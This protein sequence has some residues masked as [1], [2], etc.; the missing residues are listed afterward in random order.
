MICSPVL[1]LSSSFT[2]ALLFHISLFLRCTHWPLTHCP[3]HLNVMT[4]LFNL[5]YRS[6][7]LL[8]TPFTGCTI[9]YYLNGTIIYWDIS[10]IFWIKDYFQCLM[11]INRYYNKHKG[12]YNKYI[13]ANRAFGIIYLIKLIFLDMRLQILLPSKTLPVFPKIYN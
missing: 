10:L 8:P 7:L 9:T 3:N 12:Y 6:L 4:W 2:N 1:S 11:P 5:V 13:H